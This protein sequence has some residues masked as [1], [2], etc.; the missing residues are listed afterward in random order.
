MQEIAT[1]FGCNGEVSLPV[2]SVPPTLGAGSFL[3]GTSL[4]VHVSSGRQTEAAAKLACE[5]GLVGES[6]RKRG[7]NDRVS[8]PQEA[9]RTPDAQLLEMRKLEY[10]GFW[11]R[12]S[13]CH[14]LP[15]TS[16]DSA[17]AH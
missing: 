5:M 10:S 1:D 13:L 6:G 8:G 16:L 15:Q 4:C 17:S 2:P 3:R 12:V 11:V 7:I 14:S 9:L